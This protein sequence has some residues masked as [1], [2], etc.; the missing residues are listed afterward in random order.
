MT[1]LLIETPHDQLD[2][3]PRDFGT[4]FVTRSRDIF[5]IRDESCRQTDLLTNARALIL[6]N[7]MALGF[8]DYPLV[9]VF[10]MCVRE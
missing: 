7:V 9:D 2:A 4:S 3:D 5:L 6:Q 8:F 1:L 10:D